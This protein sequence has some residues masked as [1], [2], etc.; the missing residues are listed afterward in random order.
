MIEVDRPPTAQFAAKVS[1]VLRR[2]AP[3]YATLRRFAPSAPFCAVLRRVAPLGGRVSSH[4]PFPVYTYFLAGRSVSIS[5]LSPFFH[6]FG[7]LPREKKPEKVKKGGK[8]A[9]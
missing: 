8:L 1:A 7:F 9:Y 5:Q 3:L 2:F 6:F 4:S